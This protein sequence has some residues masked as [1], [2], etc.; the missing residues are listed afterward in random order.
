MVG[1]DRQLDPASEWRWSPVTVLQIFA[2]AAV[3][4]GAPA[5]VLTRAPLRQAVVVGN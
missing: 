3:A 1:S 2:L 4:Q 5:V